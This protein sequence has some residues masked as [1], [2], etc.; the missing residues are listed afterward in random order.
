MLLRRIT[1]SDRAVLQA[2]KTSPPEA[3]IAVD[4][5]KPAQNTLPAEGIAPATVG[6]SALVE[7]LAQSLKER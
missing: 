4:F 6:T 5:W 3:E 2:E 7:E 1:K